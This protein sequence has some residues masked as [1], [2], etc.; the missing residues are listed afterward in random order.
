MFITFSIKCCPKNY[1]TNYCAV[2]DSN[3]HILRV[4]S[5]DLD[6]FY[7]ILFLTCLYHKK[8]TF[9]PGTFKTLHGFCLRDI[10]GFTFISTCKNHI[11]FSQD[12]FA[13]INWKSTKNHKDEIMSTVYYQIYWCRKYGDHMGLLQVLVACI[14]FLWF[15]QQI[16][17]HIIKKNHFKCL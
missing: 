15:F 6:F 17:W 2:T 4:K 14:L 8:L 5:Y 12:H 7:H 16:Y 13:R 11:W 1:R 9:T 3:P 10:Q